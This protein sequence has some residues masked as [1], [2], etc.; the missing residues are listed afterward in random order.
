MTPQARIPGVGH[1]DLLVGESQII[2]CDGE[3]HHSGTQFRTD[4]ARDLAAR[5]LGYDVLR[6]SY[7]QIWVTWEETNVSRGRAG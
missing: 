1:V 2:E 7:E 4:R 6:L 5:D 3:V